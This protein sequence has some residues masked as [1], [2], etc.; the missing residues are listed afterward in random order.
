MNVLQQSHWHATARRAH[1]AP[2]IIFNQ[3]DKIFHGVHALQGVSFTIGQGEIHALLGANGAGK[4]TLI[5]VLS[6]LYRLDG[7]QITVSPG[8]SATPGNAIA[9]IHQDLALVQD[10]SVAENIAMV[11]GF[12]RRAGR[13]S[14]SAVRNQAVDALKTVSGGINVEAKVGNLS[15][16]DQSLIAIARAVSTNCCAIVLD[17]PTASLPDADVDRLFAILARLKARG[18]SILYVTHRLDEVRRIADQVTVLRDGSVVLNADIK[19]V[20]DEQIVS[21]IV[22]GAGLAAIARPA[23]T[24]FEGY[25]LELSEARVTPETGTFDLKLSKG[26]VLGLAGLRGAGHEAVGRAVAGIEPLAYARMVV[27]G[28]SVALG[29][30]RAAIGRGIGFATSRREQ[31]ALAM[32]LTARENFF[33]NPGVIKGGSRAFLSPKRERREAN[34]LA[35]SVRLRPST[36]ESIVADFSGG[37]QQK[38]VLGRLLSIDLRLMVLEEPKMGIDV[39]ARAEIYGLIQTLTAKGLGVLVVSSDFEELAAICDR[40]LVFDRGEI[41]AELKGGAL[42]TDALTHH[43]SGATKKGALQ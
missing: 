9:F 3:V 33:I 2:R 38:V 16:A 5:K 27:E 8:S 35:D 30:V 4:S 37:N 15:R 23:T 17:E 14:W 20:S 36:P 34:A 41:C 43:A 21:G 6:G 25:L 12:P 22:G 31:E 42:T 19:D 11:L 32:T 10:F 29:N 24:K 13:I 26:E 7:G 1:A 18:V 40:V 28:Q 39:G